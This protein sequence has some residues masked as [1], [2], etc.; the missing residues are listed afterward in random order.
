MYK[1]TQIY[2]Y[3]E[4]KR[5]VLQARHATPRLPSI[6]GGDL[7]RVRPLP[8]SF[9]PSTIQPSNLH[10]CRAGLVQHPFYQTSF[11]WDS[12]NSWIEIIATFPFLNLLLEFIDETNFLKEWASRIQFCLLMETSQLLTVLNQ[13][14]TAFKALNFPFQIPSSMWWDVCY[15]CPRRPPSYCAPTS[16]P[17]SPT[18]PRSSPTSPSTSRPSTGPGRPS[19]SAGGSGGTRKRWRVSS[20]S[21]DYNC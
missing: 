7:S 11:F 17:S 20:C 19:P 13:T 6:S 3:T 18:S 1:N 10:A 21:D 8:E 4:K 5:E 15:T 12:L 16:S 2:K 9:Q 14:T